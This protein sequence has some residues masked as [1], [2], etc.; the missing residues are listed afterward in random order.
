MIEGT[1]NVLEGILRDHF[2]VPGHVK[3]L[4]DPR[5]HQDID[6]KEIQRLA[7]AGKLLTFSEFVLTVYRAMDYYNQEKSHRG[8][9][10][11]WPWKPKLKN[12]VPMD[13]LKACFL[14]KNG[15]R[16]RWLNPKEIDL[17]FL[18]RADRGGRVVDRGRVSLNN[19]FYEHENLIE[20][21]KTRVDVRYDPMDPGWVLCFHDGE[22]VCRAVPIE[23]S[24]MKDMDLATRKIREKAARRKAVAQRYR[25]LTSR[26]PDFLEYSRVPQD[27]RPLPVR[28][29]KQIEDAERLRPQTEEELAADIAK[30]ENYRHENRPIFSNEVDRYQWCLSQIAERKGLSAEDRK[31]AADYEARMDADTKNYW[32]IYKE[33]LGMETA[34]YN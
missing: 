11:E 32:Q 4:N 3:R 16:P 26:V 27:E 30:I 5:E 28:N 19:Q 2:K 6:Q 9:I 22:F 17:V 21:H 31:F 33:S 1:F 10:R 7:A 29:R 34:I 20:L 12:A 13:C 18:A 8:V 24:S 15:W 14:E 23:Y 25:E